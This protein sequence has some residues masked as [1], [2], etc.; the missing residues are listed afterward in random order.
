MRYALFL[1]LVCSS[2]LAAG[3]PSEAEAQRI[4]KAALTCEGNPI[5]ALRDLTKNGS[6]A[7]ASGY[8]GAD[9]GEEL[10]YRD[11]L[12]LKNPLKI[13]GASTSAVIG[14]VEQS[15]EGF[16]GV[17]YARFHGDYKMVVKALKLKK[18]GANGPLGDFTRALEFDLEGHKGEVCP[19]TITLTPKEGTEFL[20]GCGWCNG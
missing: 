8:A 10:S 3:R 14:E 4:L 7:W 11:V 16:A 1:L 17:V 19:N 18:S 13:A 12:I 6:K 2:A 20:L 9:F 5:N 15:N